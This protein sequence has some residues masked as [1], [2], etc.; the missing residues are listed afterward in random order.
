[1][2]SQ[3]IDLATITDPDLQGAIADA[4]RAAEDAYATWIFD[5]AAECRAAVEAWRAPP[6]AQA[7]YDAAISALGECDGADLLA[8]QVVRATAG[9]REWHRRQMAW[10]AAWTWVSYAV[11]GATAEQ[12]H[13][14]TRLLLEVESRGVGGRGDVEGCATA[15]HPAFG[16]CGKG[17]RNATDGDAWDAALRDPALS[18]EARGMSVHLVLHATD[19]LTGD[20]VPS[21]DFLLHP[22][23]GSSSDIRS[24]LVDRWYRAE[25]VR[26]LVGGRLAEASDAQ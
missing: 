3:V 10:T 11:G 12:K 14:L 18:T 16:G 4:Q 19:P 9:E 7:R 17:R 8:R 26:A 24:V 1:M 25:V 15:R 13:R 20:A 21:L 2:E 5:G 6:T 23:P 22:W